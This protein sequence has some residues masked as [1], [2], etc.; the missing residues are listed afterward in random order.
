VIRAELW[1]HSFQQLANHSE[2]QRRRPDVGLGHTRAAE[3]P[4]LKSFMQILLLAPLETFS[5]EKLALRTDA[6]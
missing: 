4:V 1:R 6:P 3:L 5:K 2:A